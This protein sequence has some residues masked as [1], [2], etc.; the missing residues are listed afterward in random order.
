MRIDS[1]QHFWRYDPVAYDWID[2]TM[3]VLQRDYL[4]AD[5][6]P[7]LDRTGVQGTIA[8]Q[9]R[10]EL[11]ETDFLLDLADEYPF[12]QAVVG[13]V[14]LQAPD[15]RAQLDRYAGRPTLRGIR[16]IVQSEPDDQFMVRPAFLRG[17]RVLADYNLT[18]DLLLFPKHLRVALDVV[19]Q[20]PNQP[21]VLDHLAKP[22][23][24]AQTFAPWDADIRALAQCPNVQCKVSGMVTE[25]AWQ[26]WTLD[27]FKYYLDT[28][29]ECFGPERLMFGS[30]WPV[31]TLSAS[32][33]EVIHLVQDYIRGYAP[34]TQD[35]LLGGNAARFYG[36]PIA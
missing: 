17:L 19:Q 18:Y 2:N 29:F 20:L 33:A 14:D 23:I 22:L 28:V 25:A 1:H 24:K 10:Q 32:Y 12:V 6:K 16:H 3:A 30:D 26:Q 36:L 9:A 13:W 5:L 21:F 4:P 7:L 11:A 8:V 34:E 31:C 27:D 15:V 35:R